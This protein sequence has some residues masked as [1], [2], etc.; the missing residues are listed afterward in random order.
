MTRQGEGGRGEGAVA[1]RAARLV[2]L[3]GLQVVGGRPLGQQ[4]LVVQ[5]GR[6]PLALGLGSG[7]DSRGRQDA[8]RRVWAPW[9]RAPRASPAAPPHAWNLLFHLT[10][11]PA[12]FPKAIHVIL[13]HAL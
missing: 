1:V 2:A 8:R 9:R 3:A 6:L 10:K 11:Y 12:D 4:G 5:G 7:S 13:E